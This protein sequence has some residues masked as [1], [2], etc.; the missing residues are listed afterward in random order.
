VSLKNKSFDGYFFDDFDPIEIQPD[1]N[2]LK[3]VLELKYTQSR[4]RFRCRAKIPPS[5]SPDPGITAF[6]LA[7]Y[8]HQQGKY[9]DITWDTV[10]AYKL[11]YYNEFKKIHDGWLGR[12]VF[13]N[14]T[15]SSHP[16]VILD[17]D[18]SDNVTELI[19]KGF[20][21]VDVEGDG[22]CGYYSL[23]LGLENL[24]IYTYSPNSDQIDESQTDMLSSAPWQ[25]QVLR[26]R[27]SLNDH[28]QY[29][30]DEQYT[31]Y[32][33]HYAFFHLAGI[34]VE[35]D[36]A[37]LR[38][39]FICPG[40]PTP[41]YFNDD[42]LNNKSEYHMNPNWGAAV[43]ASLFRMR[44]IVYTR[45]TT[46]YR[47]SQTE[48]YNWNTT[49]WQYNAPVL[50]SE[51]LLWH[52]HPSI[53][54]IPDE[55]YKQLPTIE[56]LF[57]G[58]FEKNSTNHCLFLRRII[59]NDVPRPRPF[60][61]KS[62]RT[63]I[64]DSMLPTSNSGN[65]EEDVNISVVREQDVSHNTNDIPSDVDEAPTE[66]VEHPIVPDIVLDRLPVDSLPIDVPDDMVP[67]NSVRKQLDIA[68]KKSKRVYP[69]I[70]PTKK[71]H[72]TKVATQLSVKEPRLKFDSAINRF[73][74]SSFDISTKKFTKSTV[75]R[76]ITWIN[77]ELVQ[78]ARETPDEWIGPPIGDPDDRVA[79][80]LI[81]THIPV[82]YVQHDQ[83]FCLT[84]S[85]AST[86]FYCGFTEQARILSTQA[87]IFAKLHHEAA[88][89]E[90]LHF[91][92]NLAPTI[93]RPTIFGRRT[94]S[95]GKFC[96]VLTWDEVYTKPTPFPTLIIP[97]LS[98]GSM[99][100]AFCVVDNLIFDAISSSALKLCEESIKWIFNDDEV[101][102]YEAFRFNTKCSPPG[103][104]VVGKYNRK[105]NI[106]Y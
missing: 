92:S 4:F 7:A 50:Q 57:I 29:L 76:S 17:Y 49:I 87:K 23:I 41:N 31:S 24:D 27:Q 89:T 36:I 34:G 18:M 56:F 83:P 47:N 45:L 2:K 82:L 78:Q 40:L 38:V 55:E 66:V 85:F 91:M 62:L 94:R 53:Y 15:K 16:F 101:E 105:M 81:L 42:F 103:V 98:N 48:S 84:Y 72:R 64:R 11:A 1:V 51:H 6:V 74:T 106:I 25:A 99:S 32:N 33:D 59:C 54:R 61:A 5:F 13:S 69:T 104:K 95:H 26:L 67:V 46:K 102:I 10:L 70:L 28:A 14:I 22:N 19:D 100:H 97:V 86:L 88:I 79:P 93:G 9:L 90:L 96:R 12:L 21:V 77:P 68:P 35:E 80:H 43:F 63:A 3:N 37:D 65:S 39:H 58:G 20:A 75:Q 44:V 60:D 52:E 8:L 71:K 73:Y 30:L